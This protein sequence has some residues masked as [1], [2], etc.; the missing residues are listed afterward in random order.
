M[1]QPMPQPIMQPPVP[2]SK[3]MTG[4]EAYLMRARLSQNPVQT[5]PSNYYYYYFK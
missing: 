5:T 1:P 3:D 4:E 2:Q